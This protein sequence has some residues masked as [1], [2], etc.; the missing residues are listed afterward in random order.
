VRALVTRPRED[1]EKLAAALAARGIEAVLAPLLTIRPLPDSKERLAPLLPGAQAVL[2]TSANG[3]RAFA[4]A[5]E[6]R[7][8][9][10]FA[11]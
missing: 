6:R 8:L 3:V 1:A 7:D 11:P 9:P 4:A 2:F 10:I 5:A